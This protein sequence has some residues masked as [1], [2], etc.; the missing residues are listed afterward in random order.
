[1]NNGQYPNN[2]NNIKDEV[3]PL[4][5]K[6]PNNNSNINDS[7]RISNLRSFTDILQQQQQQV[8][9]QQQQQQQHQ[10]SSGR[11]SM[12]PSL[13]SNT[14][15]ASLSPSSDKNDFFQQQ[16]QQ[17]QEFNRS[18]QPQN[19]RSVDDG[20]SMMTD[21]LLTML[22]TPDEGSQYD[23]NRNDVFINRRAVNEPSLIGLNSVSSSLPEYLLSSN[24][25]RSS[26]M[27]PSSSFHTLQQQYGLNVG[28]DS[29]P[30]EV[31]QTTHQSSIISNDRG[32]VMSSVDSTTSNRQGRPSTQFFV[33]SS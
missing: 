12:R 3:G 11:H 7:P 2:R 14:S 21:A 23:S 30:N 29:D 4:Y 19:R 33:P 15:I 16:Q 13:S 10:F 5:C 32:H 17:Q 18:D 8:P 6:P 25:A 26:Q 27:N 31:G 20:L 22:D 9:Q 28:M 1:V 24:S